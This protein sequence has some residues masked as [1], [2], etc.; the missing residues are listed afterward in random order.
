MT[1]LKERT[2]E[3]VQ[4]ER[5]RSLLSVAKPS[6]LK[7]V[8]TAEALAERARAEAE[9]QFQ[10]EVRQLRSLE[11]AYLRLAEEREELEALERMAQENAPEMLKEAVRERLRFE[12]QGDPNGLERSYQ[13]ID[14]ALRAQVLRP[15]ITAM[16][17]EYRKRISESEEAIREDAKNNKIDI[18]KFYAWL[19]KS[20]K[21]NTES[22]KY[23]HFQSGRL[24]VGPKK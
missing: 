7:A 10:A 6:G 5:N 21:E 8:E 17:E 11:M 13:W 1:I 14:N 15:V 2:Q 22:K 3:E 19:G 20:A 23:I 9:E 16:T 12:C 18:A 4:D 24:F